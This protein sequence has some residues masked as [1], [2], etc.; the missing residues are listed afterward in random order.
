MAAPMSAC[1]KRPYRHA[2]P[3]SACA[4]RP[5]RNPISSTTER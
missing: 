2:P 1:A 4:K 5:Y 3:M